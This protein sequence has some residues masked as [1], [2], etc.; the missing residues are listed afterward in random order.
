MQGAKG[1]EHN[2]FKIPLGQQA[3]VRTLTNLTA[4]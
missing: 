2:A 4:G 1:Y 3:I